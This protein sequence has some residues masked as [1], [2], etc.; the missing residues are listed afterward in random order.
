MSLSDLGELLAGPY[1]TPNGTAQLFAGGVV[2]RRDGGGEL[3]AGFSF[4]PLG[5]P[6]IVSLEPRATLFEHNAIHFDP[7]G[8]D[9]DQLAQEIR[10]ALVGRLALVSTGQDGPPVPLT[11]GD[12]SPIGAPI[13]HFDVPIPEL[14]ER[15]LYDVAL[16]ADAGGWRR[17]APHAV[18]FKRDWNDF[19]IVHVTDIHVSKRIDRFKGLLEMSERPEAAA[20]VS[21]HN[22]RFRGFVRY[23][24]YLHAI[25][26]LDVILSTGDQCDYIFEEGDDP[27]GGGNAAFF[28]AL[29]LGQAP[30]PDFLDVEEL[31]VPI[32]MT[33]GNHDYRRNP[34]GL[35]F[36]LHPEVLGV[37]ADVRTIR[38]H[39]TFNLDEDGARVLERRLHALPLSSSTVDLTASQ[40]AQQVAIDK[41]LTAHRRLL[42]D[43]TSYV[44]HL[45][46]HRIV[47]IDSGPDVGVLSGV[48]DGLAQVLGFGSEDENTF[49]AGSP[50]SEGVSDADLRMVEEALA[51]APHEGLFIVGIHAPLVNQY[52]GEYPYFLR[53]TQRPFHA[54]QAAGRLRRFTSPFRLSDNIESVHPRWFPPSNEDQPPTFVV[55]GDRDDLLDYGVSRGRADELIALLAGGAARSADLVLSGHTHYHNEFRVRRLASGELRFFMDHYTDTPANYYPSRFCTEFAAVDRPVRLDNTHIEVIAGSAPDA[56]PVRVGDTEQKFDLHVPPYEDPLNVSE[57]PGAWWEKHRPVLLQTAA[58]GPRNKIPFLNGFRLFRVGGGLIRRSHFVS[59]ARLEAHDFRLPFEEAIAPDRPG[60]P[61]AQWLSVSEGGTLPGA[62]ITPVATGDDITVVVAGPSGEIYANYGSYTRRW[63]LWQAVSQGSTIP[64][65]PVCAV[66]VGGQTALFVAD[67]RGGVY[68][69][70]GSYHGGWGEWRNVSEGSTTPGGFITAVSTAARMHVFLA[71]PGGGIFVSHGNY[72][73]GWSPWRSVSEGSSTPGAPLAAVL[74]N[75]KVTVVIADPAGGIYATAG[76]YQSGWGPWRSVSEGA[77]VPRGHVSAVVAGSTIKLFLAD[78]NGGV[79]MATGDYVGGWGPWSAVSEGSTTPGAPVTATVANGRVRLTMADRNGGVYSSTVPFTGSPAAWGDISEGA[80]RPGGFVRAV[81]TGEGV[82]AF[83]ADPTGAIFARL[84]R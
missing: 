25:G 75:G 82:T 44:A 65:G 49:A 17:V 83:V 29:I 64:G 26:V 16:L 22:D 55:R 21:N 41:G 20:R 3:R 5:R 63:G 2:I 15:T 52:Y 31:R 43:R 56:E 84:I 81:A 23:A 79:Y 46:P 7:G 66:P 48:L 13:R 33:T 8:G 4:Q 42:A 51:G 27:A 18:Y 59:I 1:R 30:G 40:A 32:F 24:N 50:N 57:N 72:G 80:T 68:T 45:G 53:E 77:T 69:C 47:M 12:V 61:Q 74:L 37:G 28:R 39:G 19:G 36:D 54:R 62:S 11:L 6:I 9:L 58:L 60:P 70:L 38:N 71:D 34:Y 35:I 73:T 67:A 14:A 78:A 10:E 76:T